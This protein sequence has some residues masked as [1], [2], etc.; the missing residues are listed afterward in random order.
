MGFLYSEPTIRRDLR[1]SEA[2]SGNSQAK[3]VGA[4]SARGTQYVKTEAN[5]TE[6]DNLLKLPECR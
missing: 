5:D 2:Q 4:V 6:K 1:I 3:L